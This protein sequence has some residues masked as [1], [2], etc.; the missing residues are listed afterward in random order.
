MDKEGFKTTGNNMKPG[1]SSEPFMMHGDDII[2]YDTFNKVLLI[3]DNPADAKLVEIYIGES[4]MVNCQ[5]TH[6][7][8]LSEGMDVLAQEE[9]FAAI[10]L[11]LTLPDSRGFE[12]L[13]TLITKYPD[14]NVIVLTGLQDTSLGINAV[15]AG[16]QDFLIKGKFDA[17]TLSKSL[18]YS[19]ERNSVLKRLEETQRIAH[20]GNW[21]FDYATNEFVAS[22]EVYRIF[23]LQPRK[24]ILDAKDF[25]EENHPFNVF[26]SIHEKSLKLK[27]LKED[28]V[29]TTVEGNDRY[30]FIQTTVN[31]TN[32]NETILNGIIQD[33]TDRK[34]SEDELVTSKEQYLELFTAS[35]EAIFTA[36]IDGEMIDSN[37]AT[38]ELFG[39]EKN[40]VGQYHPERLIEK[41]DVFL[42]RLLD[43]KSLKDYDIVIDNGTK[44]YCVINATV[45]ESESGQVFKAL[46]RDMTD[47]KQAEELRKARDI[48]R[49]SAEMKEQ[50]IANIS[51][52]MRTPMNA[53]LGMSNLVI[54]TDLNK[55]QHNYIK[56]IKNS[57]EIL[58][59]IVN[60]ILEISTLQ[61][62]KVKFDNKE[63]DLQDL[64]KNIINVMQ[65]KSHEKDLLL[66]LDIDP[67]LPR[68]IKGD[69][70]RIS[71]IMYNLVGNAVKFTDRGHVRLEVKN[72]NETEDSIHIYFEVEDTGIGIPDDKLEAI[73]ET[74]T[75]I[76]TKERLFE[77][78]GLGLSIA[79]N[80]IEL[81]GGRI[82]VKSK[83]GSGSR[84]YF[85][86]IFEKGV[87][88]ED[89]EDKID[90]NLLAWA[91]THEFRLLLVEDH[92]MNQL[93]ARKTLEKNYA[94]I[95]VT[96]ADNGKIATELLAKDKFDIVLMDI[97]MPVMDGNEAT[98][99]IRNKMPKEVATLPIL[100]M[101]AHAH[102]SK[103]EKYK[104]YGMDD[105]VLKPFEPVELFS[106]IAKYLKIKRNKEN[107]GEN[108]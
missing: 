28:M 66:K 78:T 98:Q 103:D 38:S 57:S 48:A 86:L 72:L 20:I 6:K 74:F 25:T 65:Y 23:G 3:E 93:V 49:Q 52:E 34:K 41:Y 7:M 58:L 31:K 39:F 10:I 104:E 17:E 11:D 60:D 47:M 88:V 62:G 94:N 42:E 96:I 56:S 15:K 61:Q 32:E 73:F 107:G 35:N 83:L 101:T 36:S 67:T 108:I 33:V 19:I 18:R 30:A 2:Q 59:G 100:A 45:G 16:A 21:E 70:L 54:E 64:L 14:N 79:K 63:L 22:D 51:H 43:R 76:R 1:V 89:S 84:F 97:Q 24:T 91:Q 26:I 46:V 99:Y 12:T 9:G 4:D 87:A 55:E 105:F 53:I 102:I 44:R 50:F 69:K 27:K 37:P 81:Q 40:K 85:D 8:T 95:N 82:G 77:G 5:L 80:L 29:I 106:K 75:R 90:E 13:E 71:Q 68:V 92:K